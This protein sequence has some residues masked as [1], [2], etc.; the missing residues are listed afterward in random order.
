MKN[1]LIKH[2]GVIAAYS[3]LVIILTWPVAA[4]ISTHIVGSGGDP[5][6]TLWRLEEK[7]SLFRAASITGSWGDVVKHEFIGQGEDRLINLSAWPWL[8]VVIV[9]GAVRGYN[10]IWL[11]SFVLAGYGMYLLVGWL[12]KTNIGKQPAAS[13]ETK[14]KGTMLL[15]EAP[16]FL[17]G[18]AY[19]LLPYHVAHARGHFGAMQI[20]WLPF[21]ILTA[22]S[23]V[24]I[25]KI[26]KAL[27]LI[28][29]ITIQ[30]WTEHHY[31]L[32]LVILSVWFVA[33]YWREVG[34]FIKNRRGGWYA[35]LVIV[36]MVVTVGMSLAPTIKLASQENGQLDLGQEQV[37]RYS[38]DPFAYIV[39]ASFHTLWGKAAGTIWGKYF[40]GNVEEATLFIGLLPILM[41]LFFRQNIPK[42]EQ[43]FWFIT[44]AIFFVISLGPKLHLLG[45]V[46]PI[47]LPWKW[48]NTWPLLSAVRTMARAGIMVNLAWMVLFGW[49][50]ATQIKRLGSAGVVMAII[51]IEFLLV[52][53]PMMSAEM[54]RVYE[55]LKGRPGQAII[56]IP[57]ATNY[58]VASRALYG[59]LEHGKRVIN[60]IALERAE[61]AE[62]YEEIKSLPAV[63]QLMYLRTSHLLEQ[64]NEFM[65]Q[66]MVETMADVLNWLE[67]NQVIVHPDSLS[68]TQ[69]AAV[70]DFL[71]RR[72]EL[73][74]EVVDDTWLYDISQLTPG[75]GVFVARDDA[76]GEVGKEP[77]TGE[78]VAGIKDMATLTI[79]NLNSEPRNLRVSWRT[80]LES[81]KRLKF[82][83]L[84]DVKVRENEIEG[85]QTIEVVAL[86]G[87]STLRIENVGEKA[88]I[89]R[90]PV[91]QVLNKL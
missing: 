83:G 18:M 21:I 66:E 16:A 37:V 1:T 86:S 23:L 46:T 70:V 62:A 25:P 2:A 19:L 43:R 51:I 58:T 90:Q 9:G 52:P 22:W 79:Y 6:Q 7:A 81:A 72:N 17:A 30:A 60:N 27:M 48:F 82:S 68:E 31:F 10:V 77:E 15:D 65:E 45:Y 63:R 24:R 67:V 40:T 26:W 39:P 47:P 34:D 38:A 84:P 56:E 50:L 69:K 20:Q 42:A 3:I 87:R 80:D 53:M 54:P 89:I 35:G 4:K 75:D 13:A 88:I 12:V 64:R 29:L 59:S 55:V 14:T 57:T 11:A 85:V 76:W 91:M 28:A 71:E 49:V 74:R 73:K 36:G 5:W 61:G 41:V 78:I 33:C 8:P 44:A 32:W